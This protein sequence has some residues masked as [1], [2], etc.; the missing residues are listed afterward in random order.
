[1]DLEGGI[2]EAGIVRKDQAFSRQDVGFYETTHIAPARIVGGAEICGVVHDEGARI[3]QKG[4]SE[5]LEAPS[6]WDW[7]FPG[8][9]GHNIEIFSGV[10]AILV[11][12]AFTT[13]WHTPG[14]IL[15]AD[16]PATPI[17]KTAVLVVRVSIEHGFLPLILVRA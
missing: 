5:S 13:R 9:G 12:N 4:A 6:L 2:L 15:F 14:T 16:V 10:V 17:L 3:Q 8:G 1:V 11:G 7:K